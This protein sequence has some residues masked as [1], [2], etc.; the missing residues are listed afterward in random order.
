VSDAPRVS[1][2]LATYNRRNYLCQALDSL[3]AQ[4]YEDFE[5]IVGN[6]GGPD[7]IEPVKERFV[8]ERIVWADHPVRKG[9]LGN[10]LDGF[11]RARGEFLAILQ[12][13]DRWAPDLL[14]RLVPR[15][16]ADRAIN[17]A[18]SDH[19]IINQ[20]GDVDL[21]S[22][23]RNSA[24]WGRDRL[25]PGVHRPFRR[26][27][28]IDGTIP[29]QCAAVF[30]RSAVDLASFPA[31]AGTK[32]DRWLSWELARG[33]AGAYYEPARL[34]YYRSHA[35]QQTAVGR[36]E[37]AEAGIYIFQRFLAEPE[38]ADLPRAPLRAALAEE[39]YGAGVALIRRGQ[40]RAARR[41]LHE[42]LR[43]RPRPRTGAA[44]LASMLPVS[45]AT[46]L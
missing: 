44:I 16:E 27:A 41:Q 35:G 34:A 20:N 12:D 13:D 18:F 29:I 8:D 37:N 14:G 45:V 36:L 22:S 19:F 23:D 4:T 21:A 9:L 31:R 32:F 1:V 11:S 26:L 46:R 30:R 3:L 2:A 15:L 42:A 43:L 6:D 33:N 28:V 38:L 10:T 24:A 5:V 25:A 7:Y 17:V 40:P 39:H